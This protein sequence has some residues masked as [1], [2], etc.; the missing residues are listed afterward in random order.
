[1]CS[2]FCT[3]KSHVLQLCGTSGS[4]ESQES[5]E[6]QSLFKEKSPERSVEETEGTEETRG[7]DAFGQPI[8]GRC[9]TGSRPA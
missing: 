9:C 4:Q 6:S 2:Y 5:Q 1:M 8:R 7:L 3:F